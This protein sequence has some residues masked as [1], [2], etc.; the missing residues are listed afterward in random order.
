VTRPDGYLHLIPEDY[1]MLHFERGRLDPQRFWHVV[2]NEFGPATGTDMLS[3]RHAFRLLSNLGLEEIRV[4][5]VIVDTVRVPRETFAAILE[6]WRDGFAKP[7][8]DETSMSYESA[9]EHF[10]Q[11]IANVRDPHGYA[12]WMVP[13]VSGRVALPRGRPGV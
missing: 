9:L 5:Y 13:V 6:A 1:G 3:G 2:S 12:A 8:G 11:M 7:I 4:D 10:E